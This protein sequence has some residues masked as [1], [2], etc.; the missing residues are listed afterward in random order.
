MQR[1]QK[2]GGILV[3]ESKKARLVLKTLL[4]GVLVALLAYILHPKVGHI[5]ITINGEPV[6]NPLV[7]IAALPTF[8]AILLLTGLLI[9][10][11][12][13]GVGTLLFIGIVLFGTAGIVFAAPY[14]WPV[15][16]VIVLAIALSSVVGRQKD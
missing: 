2:A 11:I 16:L 3:V 12:F 14:F 8:L 9:G 10:L 1:T 15:L 6:A 5:S 7:G 4:L 13:L